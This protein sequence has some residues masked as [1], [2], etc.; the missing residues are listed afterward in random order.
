[1]KTVQT[2][3]FTNH[4]QN[5]ASFSGDGIFIQYRTQNRLILFSMMNQKGNFTISNTKKATEVAERIHLCSNVDI[6]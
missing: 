1:M 3:V 4:K 6:E 2:P 5:P